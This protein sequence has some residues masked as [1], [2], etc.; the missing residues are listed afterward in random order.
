[1]TRVTLKTCSLFLLHFSVTWLKLLL[2]CLVSHAA[3]TPI[4][5]IS[6]PER[7][8]ETLDECLCLQRG[9]S[10]P[11]CECNKTK[12]EHNLWDPVRQELPRCWGDLQRLRPG[13]QLQGLGKYGKWGQERCKEGR[14]TWMVSHNR[15]GFTNQLKVYVFILR[16]VLNVRK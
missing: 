10:Q 15:R 8:L 3:I 9:Q 14:S 16:A 2:D 6:L 7:D 12:I 4:K 13:L 5:H 11:L 1:M